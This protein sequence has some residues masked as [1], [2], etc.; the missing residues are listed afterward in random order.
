[1]VD[2]LSLDGKVAVVTGGGN[3]MGERAAHTMAARGAAVVVAD[4]DDANGQ[5]VVDDIVDAGG[6]AIFR[7]ADMTV[8]E[9]VSDLVATTVGEFGGIDILDNNAAALS[10]TRADGSLL[11]TTQETFE[12]TLLANVG[13]P[14]LMCQ[15]IIPVMIERGGGS[16]VNIASISALAGELSLTAY[17]VSKAALAQLTR[18]IATQ[19][20]P[21]G[22]RCNSV[23]PSYV[24]TRNNAAGAP[25]EVERVYL[26]QTP[27]GHIVSPQDVA[28]VVA[29]LASDAAR[30]IN[31][32]LI[33]VDGGLRAAASTVADMRDIG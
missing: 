28:E 14:F 6:Q 2:L 17:G 33:P 22:I 4:I 16:I 7:H 27:T 30:Q 10:L 24:S 8:P 29:F 19:F 15:K 3:G 5:R 32:Q 20:G 12:A 25:P 18:A 9:S 13:G 23:A 21:A 11:E 1:M 26:R 31:G